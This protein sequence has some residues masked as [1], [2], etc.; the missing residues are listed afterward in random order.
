[1]F[2]IPILAQR[3]LARFDQ[4]FIVRGRQLT[5][6]ASIGAAAYPWDGVDADT[7]IKHADTAMYQAKAAGRN[8]FQIF[9][10][11]MSA[12]A[13]LRFALED[14][15]RSAVEG[16]RLVVHY[17]PKLSIA[18]GEIVGVEA[19]ARWRHPHL[20]FI[21]PWAFIPLAEE[22]S[23]V[24]SLGEWVLVDACRQSMR[25]Q[26]QGLRPVPVA[27]N[28]SPRQFAHQP[29]V[30]MVTTA[31]EHTGLDPAL[32]ELEVTESVIVQRVEE[33]TE[34]LNALRAMGVRCS[35]DDFGT[36]YSALNYLAEMPIDAIKIDSSFVQKIGAESSGGAPIVGAVIALAHSLGLIVVAEGVE[37]DAQLRFLEAHGCDQ[38]Q[39]FRFSPPVPAEEIAE[40]LRA[41]AGLFT[42][43]SRPRDE[44]V[45]PLSGISSARLKTLLES[46][47][48]DRR[49]PTELDT[50]AIEQVLTAL[51][52]DA[53][54]RKRPRKFRHQPHEP[55]TRALE[56]AREK[57]AP[58]PC[59]PEAS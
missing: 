55:T 21:P 5:V 53:E 13:R 59:T 50:E 10:S 42:A 12:R 36:G 29:V 45:A 23:L 37:T 56:S 41:P 6:K 27:V 15:L 18:T 44:D 51:H 3:V 31:L 22:T 47:M 49:W 8:T 1:E 46:I 7:L 39:G 33:V 30:E 40:L 16:D 34:S 24:A 35:I 38:V 14:S 17:Q 9:D 19:L 4:P 11:A 20:G 52:A 43:S 28:L 57:T 26:E 32:L 25:W 54:A 2:W 48:L 58:E